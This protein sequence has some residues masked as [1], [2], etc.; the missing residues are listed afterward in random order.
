MFEAHKCMGRQKY[1]AQCLE[2]QRLPRRP[3]DEDTGPWYN[4]KAQKGD[5]CN[6]QI[7]E[8]K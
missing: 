3:E 5:Y 2:C 7:K 8:K 4:P 6:M 1:K